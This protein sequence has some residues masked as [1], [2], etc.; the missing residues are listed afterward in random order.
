[1][2]S[3]SGSAPGSTRG[4][5]PV[6]T[7]TTSASTA[8]STRRRL[9]DDRRRPVQPPVPGTTRT[10]SRSRRTAMS[11][12]CAGAS[13]LT[14]SLT[15]ARSTDT[16]RA[17]GLSRREPHAQPAALGRGRHHLRGR[18]QGLARHAVGQHRRPAEPVA[19]DDGDLGTE[20]RCHQRRLV[21]AGT[22]AD[23]HHSRHA[24]HCRAPGS[25]TLRP[26]VAMLT[27]RTAATSTRT[28]CCTGSRAH[29]PPAPDGSSA[30]G[31]PSAARTSAGRA[32]WPRSSRTRASR[33]S[34]CS[35]T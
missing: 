10:P 18:D 9:G 8:C 21:P 16:S 6:A 7:R 19:V 33:C 20:L 11:S 22:A 24:R 32:R 29:R 17:V 3:P 13:R 12:D 5:A 28:R 1:M 30:G 15:A 4:R 31:S 35:T 25:G 2:R 23:D 14:R 26:L 27:R 34:S